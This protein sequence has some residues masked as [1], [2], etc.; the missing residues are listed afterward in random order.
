M[1]DQAETTLE[2]INISGSSPKYGVGSTSFPKYFDN[3]TQKWERQ[4]GSGAPY[5]ILCGVTG[6]AYVPVQVTTD[7]KL[8]C[9]L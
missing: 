4:S 3:T 5:S 8:V 9:A 6:S 1:S 7:G 2:L